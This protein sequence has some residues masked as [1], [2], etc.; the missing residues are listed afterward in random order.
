MEMLEK[1]PFF[2]TLCSKI[3]LCVSFKI[4]VIFF[5]ANGIARFGDLNLFS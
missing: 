3:G 5:Q 1:I 2:S 4:F